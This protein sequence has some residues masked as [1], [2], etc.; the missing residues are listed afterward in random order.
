MSDKIVNEIENT[1]PETCKEFKR[2]QKEQYET[3]CK[4]QHD[5]GQHNITLGMDMED[6]ESRHLSITAII[7]R[8]NDKVQRL[9]N[10]V[11]RRKT[12]AQNE[13]VEDAFKDLA[14]YGIIA[15]I[16]S[17]GKWGK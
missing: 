12:T 8:I 6:P 16:V 5:Y 7:I 2:I 3:F 9:F 10:L 11:L 13:P 15:Q 4:K 1:F 17:N 14:V